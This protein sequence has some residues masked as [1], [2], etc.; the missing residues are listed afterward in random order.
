MSRLAD[1]L[2]KA[3]AAVTRARTEGGMRAAAEHVRALLFTHEPEVIDADAKA[4]RCIADIL[5]SMNG[6]EHSPIQ[7]WLADALLAYGLR[8]PILAASAAQALLD[9][10]AE[11]GEVEA[12]GPMAAL[13]V[14]DQYAPAPER[15]EAS[16]PDSMHLATAL[17]MRGRA[18]KDLFAAALERGGQ[19]DREAAAAFASKAWANYKACAD[20]VDRVASKLA[21]AGE[22]PDDRSWLWRWPRVNMITVGSRLL[23]EDLAEAAGFTPETLSAS[24]KEIAEPLQLKVSQRIDAARAALSG[25]AGQTAPKEE[26]WDHA[27]LAEIALGIDRD[28]AAAKSHIEAFLKSLKAQS[29]AE[30]SGK[31]FKLLGTL[32]Q[33]TQVAA[34]SHED[35]APIR[36]ALKRVLLSFD[37]VQ[38]TM[39]RQT[40][41]DVEAFG[42]E[43][44]SERIIAEAWFGGRGQEM[45]RADTIRALARAAEATAVILLREDGRIGDR[46]ASGFAIRLGDL[47]PE[48]DRPDRIALV[49]NAH[50][51]A[52]PGQHRESRRPE[53]LGAFFDLRPELGQFDLLPYW[54]GLAW[55]TDVGW[56]DASVLILKSRDG[57]AESSLP[58]LDLELRDTAGQFEN[59][60]VIGHPMGGALQ[61]SF[62]RNKV[63]APSRDAVGR[64]NLLYYE[65]RTERGQSGGPV[66]LDTGTA[67]ELVAVHIG[68]E[69]A[70][71]LNCGVWLK[72]LRERETA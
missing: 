22:P 49:T 36:L 58:T 39:D 51:A 56:L 27:T 16:P 17:G 64:G 45:V 9:M 3:Q 69:E 71:K 6:A 1:R 53:E 21:K 46:V 59:A 32:R 37:G 10:R 19:E 15:G 62:G 8:E 72:R 43:A 29:D 18:F 38:Q 35:L 40:L 63:A 4:M 66:L 28:P 12:G 57:T 23:A 20:M 41:A 34:G 68:A 26:P 55:P 52:W 5:E 60:F 11:A 48:A 61:L 13:A 44:E 67:T 7:F 70:E 25:P 31:D 54:T 42:T 33:F 65:S 2:A 47:F 30:T 14:L 24:L 50:V